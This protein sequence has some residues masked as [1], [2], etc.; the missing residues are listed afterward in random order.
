ML[1]TDQRGSM[2]SQREDWAGGGRDPYQEGRPAAARPSRGRLWR[3]RIAAVLIVALIP[4]GW[5]YGHALTVPGG[6][7]VGVQSVEWIRG[8]GGAG[9]VVAIENFWYTHHPPPKG[10]KP[11]AG[12][13]PAGQHGVTSAPT[14][15]A[16]PVVLAAPAPIPPIVSPALANEGTWAP[17][18]REVNGSPAI[19]AAYVRP[20][21]VHTSLVTGVAWMNPKLLT[22]KLFAGSQEPGGGPWPYS[23]P[24]PSSMQGSLVAAFN[25]GFRMQDANGGY[26]AYGHTGVPLVNGAAS[27]VINTDGTVN[28]GT[29]GTGAFRMSPTVAAVRQNLT[30]IVEG[31]SPVP[32]LDSGSY[33]KWGATVGNSVLVWRSGVG[34]TANGA[35]LYAAGAGLSAYSL[36]NV[37][38]RAGAVRAM[39]MDINSDWTDYFSFNP[40]PGQPAQPSN[41]AKLVPDMVQGPSRYFSSEPRDFIAMLAR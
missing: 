28:V 33:T 14:A 11:P 34:V 39:E 3:R 35:L 22:A 2:T 10:G 26:Y 9:L 40:A 6:A 38:A 41:G 30:L 13:I 16:A 36:A 7:G 29:W 17:I 8:H 12:Y 4:V 24:I 27:L 37:L 19:Y 23:A 25:S 20:D 18:G 21:A 1:G 15:P 32:G 31:G 5:S